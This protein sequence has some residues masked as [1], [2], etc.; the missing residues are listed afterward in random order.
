[1][2]LAKR[3]LTTIESPSAHL[4]RFAD[5]AAADALVRA[6]AETLCAADLTRSGVYIALTFGG[7]FD[8]S[9]S[10]PTRTLA[11][12]GKTT[13]TGW[14]LAH[15]IV[16]AEIERRRDSIDDAR[17]FAAEA[18]EL[19]SKSFRTLIED[20][21]DMPLRQSP[22]EVD[23]DVAAE[24]MLRTADAVRTLFAGDAARAIAR[25]ASARMI[26]MDNL[27]RSRRWKRQGSMSSRE[28]VVD[29]T[30]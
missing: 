25:A 14:V 4:G 27:Q 7:L 18:F 19:M 15:E 24:F 6:V 12:R 2:A 30:T 11:Q 28:A 23:V 17:K 22:E 13:L 1:M 16:E 26:Y 5:G 9:A 29:A 21:N 20:W 8:R 3:A 10:S